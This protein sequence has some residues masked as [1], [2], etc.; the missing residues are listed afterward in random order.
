[1]KKEYRLV[2][3]KNTTSEILSEEFG[4]WDVAAYGEDFIL[5][6][7]EVEDKLEK[8]FKATEKIKTLPSLVFDVPNICHCAQCCNPDVK[9]GSHG[10]TKQSEK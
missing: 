5:F 7:K 1:M 2:N 8:V 3:I 6:Q 9:I 10:D 4:D